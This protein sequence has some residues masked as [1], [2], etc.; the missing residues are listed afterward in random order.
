ME[1]NHNSK[2][3]LSYANGEAGSLSSYCY[4]FDSHTEYH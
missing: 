4:E 3:M 1:L 2:F